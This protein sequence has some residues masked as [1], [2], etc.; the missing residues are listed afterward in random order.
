[1]S[2]NIVLGINVSKNTLSL[3]I[4]FE[5]GKFYEKVVSNSISGFECILKILNQKMINKEY[6]KCIMESTGSYSE[7]IADFLYDNGFD[8]KVVNPYKIAD[9]SKSKLSRIKTDKTDARL[10]AE[11]GVLSNTDKSYKKQPETLRKIR[12]YIELI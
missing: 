9:F 11:Y 1:M 7:S 6:V 2:N 12:Y 10:I 8:V 5:S 3:A 4:R